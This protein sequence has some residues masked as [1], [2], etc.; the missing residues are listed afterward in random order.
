MSFINEQG[1]KL[2]FGLISQQTFTDCLTMIL[3]II[4]IIILVFYVT[5]NQDEYMIKNDNNTNRNNNFEIDLIIIN[6]K[7]EIKMPANFGQGYLNRPR[8]SSQYP[9]DEYAKI[10]LNFNVYFFDIFFIFKFKFLNFKKR[11]I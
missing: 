2:F 5:N 8:G 1:G 6:I 9:Y 7:I 11:I 3:L 10:Q 4:T